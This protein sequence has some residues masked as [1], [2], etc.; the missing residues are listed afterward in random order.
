[1]KND[2]KCPFCDCDLISEDRCHNCN[3]FQIVGYV[4][5][6]VRRKITLTS[7]YIS[8]LIMLVALPG[9]FLLSL[10]MVFYFVIIVFSVALFFV[11]QRV[12][13]LKEV[14]KGRVVWKRAMV[15]W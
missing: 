12:L 15:T 10:G 9:I 13:Y 11:T 14:R 7:T 3:A 6:A 8:S 2:K 4:P 1:M 5:G